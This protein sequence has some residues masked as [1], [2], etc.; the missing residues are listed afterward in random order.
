MRTESLAKPRTPRHPPW[1]GQDRQDSA[2]RPYQ[3][4]ICLLGRIDRLDVPN[5][6]EGDSAP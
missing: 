5:A 2:T 1:T 3:L 6:P 4:Q